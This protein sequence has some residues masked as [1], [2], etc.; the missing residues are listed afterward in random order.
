MAKTRILGENA[1][2]KIRRMYHEEPDGSTT[3][4]TIQDVSDIVELTKAE[5]K[6]LDGTRMDEFRNLIGRI[7]MPIYFALKKGTE[8]QEE[9]D[10]RCVKW[11][12]EH[13][14]FMSRHGRFV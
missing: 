1:L 13:P 9:W 7:P 3:I 5:A 12:Q 8:S 10:M 6:E 11:L 2:Q 14:D 4:Q